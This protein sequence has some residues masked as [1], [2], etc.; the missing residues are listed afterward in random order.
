MNIDLKGTNLDLTPSLKTY[1]NEK[2]SGITKIIK[3][4]EEDGEAE[5]RIEVARTTKHHYK[6][7]VFMAE[8]N[9]NVNGKL[10]R[11]SNTMEDLYKA[12]DVVKDE[13]QLQIEKYKD[14]LSPRR[15]KTTDESI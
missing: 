10:F 8:A 11:A 12:I 4:F 2:F 14:K 7:D 3:K 5:L 1:I 15:V 9:L 13:I 6:G